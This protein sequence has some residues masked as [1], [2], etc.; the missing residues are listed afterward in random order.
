[1]QTVV[2]SCDPLVAH[3]NSRFQSSTRLA[4]V[5]EAGLF[6]LLRFNQF[7]P[8]GSYLDPPIDLVLPLAAVA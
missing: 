1:M 6:C 3:I 2:F 5:H 4:K 8:K 7:F